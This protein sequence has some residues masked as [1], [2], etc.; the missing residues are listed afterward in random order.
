M[1]ERKLEV[2][3][4]YLTKRNNKDEKLSMDSIDNIDLIDGYDLKNCIKIVGIVLQELANTKE[5]KKFDAETAEKN[6]N[7]IIKSRKA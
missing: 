5:I 7:S 6:Y 1:E 2:I 4:Y 3:R